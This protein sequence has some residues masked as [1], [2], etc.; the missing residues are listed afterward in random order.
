MIEV[1]M[2]VRNDKYKDNMILPGFD[3]VEEE[4]Q[5]AHEIRL[6]EDVKVEERLRSYPI[7]S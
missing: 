2:Q 6:K 5:I 4:E 7:S 3:L 1:L